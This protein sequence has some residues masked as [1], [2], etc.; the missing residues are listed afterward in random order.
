MMRGAS[1]Q[2]RRP[3]TRSDPQSL[4]ATVSPRLG[5]FS[6]IRHAELK[7]TLAAV[8]ALL[9]LLIAAAIKNAHML[10]ADGV[11]YLRLASYAA[12]GNWEL[13]VSGYW[14]PLASWLMAPLLAC[15]LAPLTAARVVMGL[16]ALVYWW[17]CVRVF[18]NFELPTA[19]RVV[20]AW[21]A[22][23]ASV[24]WSVAYITP[25]LLVSGCL[26]IGIGQMASASWTRSRWQQASAGVAFG[27]AYLSKPVG[28]PLG[29][30]FIGGIALLQWFHSGESWRRLVRPTAMTA[31]GFLLVAGPWMTVLS[32]KYHRPTFAT[33]G[34]IA[35]ATAGP[36]DV[37]RGHPM[38]RLLHVPEEGRLTSWEDPT[39]MPYAYWSPFE[40]RDYL[41]YQLGMMA[42]NLRS[43]IV[44]LGSLEG[45]WLGMGSVVAC[46][47]LAAFRRR[48]LREQWWA[49]AW[50]PLVLLCGIYWPV[51]RYEAVIDQ[52]YFYLGLPFLMTCAF[53][54]ARFAAQGMRKHSALVFWALVVAIAASFSRPAWNNMRGALDGLP[55][56]AS[57]TARILANRL[58]AAGIDGPIAGSAQVGDNRAGLFVAYFLNTPWH[59]D[60]PDATAQDY[61][62]SKARIIIIRRNA[63]REPDL[64]RSNLLVNLDDV[65]FGSSEHAAQF[66]LKAYQVR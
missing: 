51:Y 59:G 22:A 7:G 64:D 36:P 37:P 57:V 56:P 41:R 47:V 11:A 34:P 24:F 16:S 4:A 1:E 9:L 21:I 63:P 50:V 48:Q 58:A 52:R 13:M 55:N 53:G 46:I 17:G 25:D 29:V 26:G 66:P 3:G 31:L 49:W 12:A 5:E 23:L 19:C 54:V 33:G 30:T 45:F 28:F 61:A 38:G 2:Q 42:Y 8:F 32:F 20:A 27:L 62:N 39:R 6:I 35:H 10:N 15:D 14:G 40:S 43:M 60:Q 65:L 18:Q 44:L